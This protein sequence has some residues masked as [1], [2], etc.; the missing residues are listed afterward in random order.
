M[1][2]V[3]SQIIKDQFITSNANMAKLPCD[4]DTCASSC[5]SSAISLS[6]SVI[7][8]K[9]SVFDGRA[10]L[11]GCPSF[12]RER[13]VRRIIWSF[14]LSLIAQTKKYLA[15]VT[16]QLAR[17]PVLPDASVRA[18]SRAS[19]WACFVSSVCSLRA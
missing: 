11:I 18:A 2:N 8:K 15:A 10:A 12:F 5:I 7:V 3:G 9:T 16:G 17:M 13:E 19:F 6:F 14:N 1:S 4:F